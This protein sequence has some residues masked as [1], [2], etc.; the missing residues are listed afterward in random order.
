MVSVWSSR[1]AYLEIL[2]IVMLI[3]NVL[4][5]GWWCRLLHNCKKNICNASWSG[6][7]LLGYGSP[8]FY[9][10]LRWFRTS[11]KIFKNIAVFFYQKVL[12]FSLLKCA[13]RL[14][15]FFIFVFLWLSTLLLKWFYLI[16]QFLSSC[17]DFSDK[18]ADTYWSRRIFLLRVHLEK[19]EGKLI[20]LV[21]V[22]KC[23]RAMLGWVCVAIIVLSSFFYKRL[24][25]FIFEIGTGGSYNTWGLCFCR[26]WGLQLALQFDSHNQSN[27][28]FPFAHCIIIRDGNIF[29]KFPLEFCCW[30]D[31]SV[32]CWMFSTIAN[33]ILIM[34][35][36]ELY[37]TK[38]LVLFRL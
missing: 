26:S 38:I 18:A 3:V 31:S 19:V 4:Q 30:S 14:S 28:I 36:V 6:Q 21:C 7:L 37:S 2:V 16:R 25:G 22:G 11:Q 12:L 34:R 13:S 27:I 33:N 1:Y 20:V 23:P 15:R 29:Q 5:I 17:I 35:K 8:L 9:S 10:L 24:D 32:L